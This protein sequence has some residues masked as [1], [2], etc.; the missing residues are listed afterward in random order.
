MRA[1]HELLEVKPFDQITIAEIVER[2]RSSVGAF[3]VRFPDKAALLDYL[4]EL[5]AREMVEA[6]EVGAR[7]S[8]SGS[9]LEGEVRGLVA[10]L[11]R[12][13][14]IRPG[15]LRTLI[16]EARRQGEGPFRERTRRMNRRIPAL[17]DRL[18]VHDGVMGHPEPRRA[19]YL[20]LLMVFSAIREVT[21]FPEG[22]AEF[23]DYEGDELIEELTSAYLRYLR[24][25]DT[26]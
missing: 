18:L 16:I 15:L 14:R 2:A 17:M 20:G 8:T 21:L 12:I 24:V 10:F 9:T 19:V 11:V 23:V 26:T 3:Y 13:H 5:Y 7:A 22:L 6:A 1:T 25:E 4:D